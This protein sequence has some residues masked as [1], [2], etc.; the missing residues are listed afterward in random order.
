MNP[1]VSR[2]LR[3]L[4]DLDRAHEHPEHVP[5]ARGRCLNWAK[6]GGWE[7]ANPTSKSNL[8]SIQEDGNLPREH[9]CTVRMVNWVSIPSVPIT[10]LHATIIN[11]W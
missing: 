3:T 5:L 1:A 11:V 7:A 8:R 6:F 10:I 4:A 2:A 9:T